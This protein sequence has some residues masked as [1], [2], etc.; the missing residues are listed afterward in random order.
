MSFIGRML[1]GV[2]A[3]E[4]GLLWN[5]DSGRAAPGSIE[6]VSDVFEG[7]TS[8]PRRHAGKGVGENMSP[9]LAWKHIPRGT[10]ELALVI[11]DADAPLACPFVHTV[12]TAIP[13]EV[14]KNPR[15]RARRGTGASGRVRQGHG[16][17]PR[18]PR[19]EARAQPRTPYLRVSGLRTRGAVAGSARLALPR[20]AREG[21]DRDRPRAW[22]SRR[23]IRAMTR[24]LPRSR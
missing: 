5:S 16:R 24:H 4:G 15:G 2:R 21:N 11:E 12:V 1:R 23:D 17:R 10:A 18:L 19:A 8:I 13:P 9:P 22:P 14:T 20:A 6:L 7:G 3:G